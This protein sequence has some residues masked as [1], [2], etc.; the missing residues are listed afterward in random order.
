MINTHLSVAIHIL[1]LIELNPNNSS[2]SI[3]QSV[4]TNPVV[5]RRISG[6][7]K[8]AGLITSKSGFSGY[9]L[10]KPSQDITLLDIYKALDLEKNLFPV[11]Q[12]PNPECPVG[13][14]N[15]RT[16]DST[17]DD[18]KASIERDLNAENR[19]DVISDLD[20]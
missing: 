11:H 16:L 17:F 6:S 1:A 14:N 5:V 15:Q 20:F 12:N 19:A 4:Q 7:L 9:T 18:V 3:A 2:D 8:K 13:K 10:A